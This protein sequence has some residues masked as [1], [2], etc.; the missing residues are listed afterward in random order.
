MFLFFTNYPN[1]VADH[2][3]RF[4]EN[5]LR[6]KYGFEGVPLTLSFKSKSKEFK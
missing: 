2:Y 6:R 1:Q 4:L 5:L 3:K